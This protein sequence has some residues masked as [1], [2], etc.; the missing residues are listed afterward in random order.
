[1]ATTN[2]VSKVLTTAGNVAMLAAGSRPSALAVGQLGAFNVHTGLSVDAASPIGD[3]RDIYLAVGVNKTGAGGGATLEDIDKSAGQFIQVRNAKSYTYRGT[4]SDT[5][6]VVDVMG[7]VAKCE[8]DYAVKVEIRNGQVYAE[9]G[10]NQFTKTFAVRTGCCAD[11]CEDCGDGNCL[12]IA[13]SIVTQINADP[14]AL[15]TAQYI[16]NAITATVATEPTASGDLT[17]TVGTT[18]YTVA[19]VDA[20]TVTTAAAKI[21]AVINAQAGSPYFASNAAGVITIYPKVSV[22]GSTETLAVTVPLAGLTITPIVAATKTAVTPANYAA[23]IAANPGVCLGIRITAVPL[24]VSSLTGNINLK[25]VKMR[26]SDL[27]VSLP[28][29]FDCNGSVAT[30]TEAA[31]GEGQGYDLRQLEYESQGN[32]GVDGTGP[33]RQSAVHGLERA[34]IVYKI[35]ASANYNTFILSYDQMSVGGWLEYLNNLETIIAV[36]CADTATTASIAAI[37]D[38][39]FTQFAPMAGDEAAN[40]GCSNVATSALV[41][42]TD[43]IESLG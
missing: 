19:I 11:A 28:L 1:M 27:I 18:S 21:V 33:Y 15:L 42:A 36:P 40:N 31:N 9:N 32:N 25:Y 38:A 8:T 4:V 22:S 34:G 3:T 13:N 30:V 20:D 16:V 39:I 29:G 12:E 24:T 10:Y 41:A 7:F 37:L 6:K 17:I 14:D 2:P 43:G 5:A 35:N 26:N 23:F